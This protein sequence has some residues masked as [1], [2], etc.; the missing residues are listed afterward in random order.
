MSEACELHY[1]KTTITIKSQ[2]N[3]FP[4]F[5]RSWI[6]WQRLI[7]NSGHVALKETGEYMT[8]NESALKSRRWNW[9]SK[10]DTS[11]TWMIT[12]H[13]IRRSTPVVAE[14]LYSLPD[15]YYSLLTYDPVFNARL[16]PACRR[17]LLPPLPGFFDRHENGNSEALQQSITNDQTAWGHI[18]KD[19]ALRSIRYQ[20]STIKRR[21]T[22]RSAVMWMKWVLW[23]AWNVKIVFRILGVWLREATA[24]SVRKV[25]LEFDPQ[26]SPN[27]P[28]DRRTNNGEEQPAVQYRANSDPHSHTCRCKTKRCIV[29]WLFEPLLT[30]SKKEIL[31]SKS[32][33]SRTHH[34][35]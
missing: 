33:Q 25:A 6:M 18:A 10:I 24:T 22:R 8:L 1:T 30:G 5:D 28:W 3:A 23:H 20:H 31:I 35:L 32:I 19:C 9:G 15:E 4:A 26:A 2:S 16:L 29:Q 27:A 21:Q 7:N 34:L 13:Y 17:S 11:G 14:G 12:E